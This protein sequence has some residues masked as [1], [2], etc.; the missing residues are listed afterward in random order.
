MCMSVDKHRSHA[1]QVTVFN[2]MSTNKKMKW[3]FMAINANSAY[4]YHFT[5]N[6]YSFS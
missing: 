4:G 3:D 2:E 6:Q 1:G 5:L